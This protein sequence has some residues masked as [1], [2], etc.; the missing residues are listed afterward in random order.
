[1]VFL[2]LRRQYHMSN[3]PKLICKFNAIS[4][5]NWIKLSSNFKC[6]KIA[7]KGRKKKEKTGGRSVYMWGSSTWP[8]YEA[9]VCKHKSL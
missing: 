9:T 7:K 6:L 8:F 2:L 3:F 4:T 5:P 1:M